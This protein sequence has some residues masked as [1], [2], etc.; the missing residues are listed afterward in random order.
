VTSTLSHPRRIEL[1]LTELRY[2]RH[3][4]RALLWELVD[5]LDDSVPKLKVAGAAARGLLVLSEAAI[6]AE[7]FVFELDRIAALVGLEV[8]AHAMAG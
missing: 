7:D 4:R 5:E 1:L 3:V 2:E 6:S 8:P